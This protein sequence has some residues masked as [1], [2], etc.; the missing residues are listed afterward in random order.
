MEQNKDVDKEEKLGDSH[1]KMFNEIK[2][3][4]AYPYDFYRTYDCFGHRI[5]PKGISI[6]N[7]TFYETLF[8]N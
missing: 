7:N 1:I 3:E 4:S 6:L 8:D 5:Y 2:E